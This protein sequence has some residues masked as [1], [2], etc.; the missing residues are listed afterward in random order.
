MEILI[1]VLRK[2]IAFIIFIMQRLLYKVGEYFSPVLRDSKFGET[3]VI[4]PE[5]FVAAGEYLTY[6]CPTWQW[7]DCGGKRSYL[8][9]DRQFLITKNV[10]CV[11]RVSQMRRA[12]V[13][14]V[15]NEGECGEW[16]TTHFVDGNGGAD[17]ESNSSSSS[18]DDIPDIESFDDVDDDDVVE[19]EKDDASIY[20]LHPLHN[21]FLLLRPQLTL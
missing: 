5:E 6:K 19:D 17:K 18:N 12:D 13:E 1:K 7:G 21:Q 20:H 11:R 2:K 15:E 16:V 9:D 4:T 10:P 8:P 3:G 14:G